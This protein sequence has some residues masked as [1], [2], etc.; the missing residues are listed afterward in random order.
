MSNYDV[1]IL[2]EDNI[3]K[4]NHPLFSVDDHPGTQTVLEKY[5]FNL[6][7]SISSLGQLTKETLL[8]TWDYESIALED[9]SYLNEIDAGSDIFFVVLSKEKSEVSV[10][11]DNKEKDTD[12][13]KTGYVVS[14]E[15]SSVNKNSNVK[16][17]REKVSVYFLCV[18]IYTRKCVTNQI[19]SGHMDMVYQ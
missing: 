16:E 15:K 19:F 13:K 1:S 8:D 18:P 5:H 17:N 10:K 9:V 4:H 12:A 6:N 3:G 2:T 14:K 7:Q 11:N